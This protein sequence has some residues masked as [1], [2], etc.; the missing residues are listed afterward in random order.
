MHFKQL[1][2]TG[3]EKSDKNV[4][5]S[6]INCHMTAVRCKTTK[7]RPPYG[8]REGVMFQKQKGEVYKENK[9]N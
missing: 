6:I 2:V 4:K 7:A 5:C 8:K 3:Q 1:K 9:R